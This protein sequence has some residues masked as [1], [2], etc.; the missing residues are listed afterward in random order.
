MCAGYAGGLPLSQFPQ[1]TEQRRAELARSSARKAY[2]IILRKG[3]TFFGVAHCVSRI[4]LAIMQDDNTILPLSV[5]SKECAAP[6]GRRP[7]ASQHHS[8]LQLP[9]QFMRVS[10]ECAVCDPCMRV[11]C[12]CSM[13]AM[14]CVFHACDALCVFHACVRCAVCVPCMRCAVCVP[15][16]RCA[17]TSKNSAACMTV[18]CSIA[19]G[20]HG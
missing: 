8:R 20:M 10:C 12:V 15:C 6:L 2:E 18:R 19:A 11:R 17:V 4:V 3:A 5:F 9:I 1:L 13:H 14:R 7:T 16:M